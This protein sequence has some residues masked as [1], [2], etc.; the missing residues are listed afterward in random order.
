M[1]SKFTSIFERV[2]KEKDEIIYLDEEIYAILSLLIEASK[3]D[4]HI[5]ES[6]INTII[7]FLIKKFHL[8]ESKAKMATEFAIEKSNDK[9]EIY[10]DIKIILNNMN[11]QQRISVIEMM[12]A[13]VL[14]DGKL[15]DYETNLMSRMCGL[16]HV[17]GIESSQAK[18]RALG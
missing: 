2:K 6:E 10:S 14:V 4:D 17:S 5:D 7:E 18:K 12:W 16:L 15:D 3:I 1:F 8:K 11:H 13:I 9:V